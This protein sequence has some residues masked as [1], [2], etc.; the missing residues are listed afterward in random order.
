M[1]INKEA[2]QL[3]AYFI[4]WIQIAMNRHEPFKKRRK[5]LHE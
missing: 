3:K 2:A 5:I 1:L 4:G